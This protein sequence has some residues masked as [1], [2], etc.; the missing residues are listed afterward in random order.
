VLGLQVK[1]SSQIFSLP[2][3]LVGAESPFAEHSMSKDILEG[4]MQQVKGKIRSAYGRAV[5][6]PKQRLKGKT[7]QLKG[8]AKKGIGK[9]KYRL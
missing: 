3:F 1:P 6:S 7:E 9:A 8:R 5:G 2:F 4:E